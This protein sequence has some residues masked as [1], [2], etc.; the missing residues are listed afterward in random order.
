MLFGG[1]LW[2]LLGYEAQTVKTLKT[3]KA[4]SREIV[5]KRMRELGDDLQA[6]EGEEKRRKNFLDILL[7]HQHENRLTS[8]ELGAEVDTFVFAGHD[9]ERLYAELVEHFGH[10]D[11]EF[12][13]KKI[14]ELPFLDACF[15]EAMRVFPPVPF[16]QR[17]LENDLEIGEH[18]IP[19][20]TIIMIP[21]CLMHHNEQ[22]STNFLRLW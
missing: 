14:H 12:A 21:P 3:L 8:E 22:A 2:K 11:A 15:K 17:W 6:V 20:H 13:T 5:N 19:K 1:L 10:S 18:L 9:T 7:E 16:V 4:V